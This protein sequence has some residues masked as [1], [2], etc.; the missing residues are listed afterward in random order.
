MLE[1]VGEIQAVCI[2]EEGFLLGFARIKSVDE[3][4]IA[5]EEIEMVNAVE[6]VLE[7][8]V[9]V[10]GEIGGNDGKL[11]LSRSSAPSR[12]K[13]AAVDLGTGFTASR[14]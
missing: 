8:V 2:N 14:A 7:G 4:R 13:I 3:R 5:E 11:I 1:L 6:R 12:G 9:G 10:N